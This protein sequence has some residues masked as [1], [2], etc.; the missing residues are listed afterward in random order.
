MPK[1]STWDY[2]PEIW[3]TEAKY[4][5][6]LRGQFRLIWRDSPQRESFLKSKRTRIPVLDANGKQV[7]VKKTGLPKM[8]NGYVC[9]FCKVNLQA[10]SKVPGSRFKPLYAVDHKIGG[11]SLK[12]MADVGSFVTAIINVRPEDLQILCHV[13]HDIKTHSEKTGVSFTMAAYDKI[14]I[15]IVKEK[16]DKN[17]FIE[18]NLEVPSNADKRRKDIVKILEQENN[19]NKCN[20]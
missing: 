16:E 13:C 19:K 5:S 14:A 3:P 10:S 20:T 4:L 9:E 8:V 1:V 12:S 6:W 15:S 2:Y 11:H 17:F 18:R 7:L